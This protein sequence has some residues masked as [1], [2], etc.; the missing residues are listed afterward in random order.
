MKRVILSFLVLIFLTCEAQNIAVDI[1]E[2]SQNRALA[3]REKTVLPEIAET[4]FSDEEFIDAD[5]RIPA[6]GLYHE[7]W[8]NDHLR[9]AQVEIP[10]NGGSLKI[11]LL[12]SY[13]TPFVFPCRGSFALAYGKTKR[14]TFHT[15]IDFFLQE[16]DPVY[17]CFDGVV[18]MAREYGDYGKIVV[19]RHYNGLETVYSHLNKVAV[20][21]N[22]IMKAGDIVGLAGKTGNT[23][24]VLLHFET[25]FFNEYFNPA[26]LIDL[27]TRSLSSNMLTLTPADFS[28]LPIPVSLLKPENHKSG[29]E[30]TDT[31]SSAT[32]TG[33]MPS[34]IVSTTQPKESAK[35]HTIQKGETL[36]RIA[37]QHGVAVEEIMKLNNI[38]NAAHIQAGQKLR[39]K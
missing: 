15:G 38:K 29:N 26:L 17:A 39:V 5:Y 13:N 35:Y 1:D 32:N 19:I 23:Q 37:N 9:S 7:L 21:E 24:E 22:Q 34:T 33:S 2:Q 27:E 8:D 16:N 11:I 3:I 10:F 36:Y 30:K 28:I 6:Y 18:R 12:E 31:L 25:R 14:N 20:S 4:D